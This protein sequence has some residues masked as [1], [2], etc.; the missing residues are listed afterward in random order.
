MTKL[1]IGF[2][3][4]GLMGSAMC[5]R[6]LDQGYELT[7]LANRSRERVDPLISRGGKEAKT[8]RQ[9]AENSD[10]VMLC[11]DT[12]ASVESRMYGED[13]VIAGLRDGA[14]AID[15]GTSLPGSTQTIGK[16]VAAAGCAYLDAPLGRTPAHAL[17]G[18]LNIMCSGDEAAY[19][20]VEPVL[21]DLGEN[22]FHLGALGTGHCIKLINNF[23]AQ[24]TANA[25]AEAY[26]IADKAGVDRDKV[27]NVM[28]E[29]PIHSGILEFIK[30]YAIDGNADMMAF[31]IRNARKDVGYYA[32]MAK[33][34]GVESMMV[35]CA[36]QAL[37][38]SIESGRG[39]EYVPKQVD[40]FDEL[41][42]T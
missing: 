14:I 18:L 28:K 34:L 27:Y 7:L 42:G 3:G 16:A 8:A 33:N 36:G 30:A 39:D 29:G 31:S 19:A 40:F 35:K 26:I 6:L 21:K 11:V 17:D 13:G 32:A 10:I 2:I 4:I 1:S 25:M 15:F 22:V 23:V 9:V 20:K 38:M 24:T 41:L 12:S 37:E 5:N